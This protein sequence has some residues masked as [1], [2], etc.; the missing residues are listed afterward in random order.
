M[1]DENFAAETAP[2]TAHMGD[3]RLAL[4]FG[5]RRRL[6]AD[7]PAA[8]QIVPGAGLIEETRLGEFAAAAARA[9]A[10]TE[11]AGILRRAVAF[12]LPTEGE[13]VENSFVGLYA[14]LESALTFQRHGGGR[15]K[16]F[17]GEEFGQL[18]RDLRAWL[19]RHPLLEGEKEKRGLIYEKIRELNRLPF[20]HVYRNFCE[21]Y[22][23]ALDD[24]WPVLGR[25]E[26]WP[27]AEIRHRLIHGDPFASCPADALACAREHLRWTVERM[28]LSSLGWPVSE[29]NASPA[30]LSASRREYQVWREE[31]AR[32]A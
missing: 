3:V 28:I 6:S 16:V 13:P 24:L 9:L 1:T 14:A 31:R 21:H 7:R 19:R 23:L 29:S 8:E 12:T 22:D 11:H 4:S 18:E 25:P 5:A 17:A 15:Y 20:T 2:P 10:R 30:R 26:E 27:L 32:F